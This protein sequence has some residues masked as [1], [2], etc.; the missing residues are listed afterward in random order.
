[1]NLSIT[2]NIALTHSKLLEFG[3]SDFSD[4]KNKYPPLGKCYK[5]DNEIIKGFFWLHSFPNKFNIKIHDFYFKENQIIELNTPKCLNITYYHSIS[6]EELNP[7]KKLH[8]NVV[9]CYLGGQKPF[10]ALIYKNK[11]LKSIGIDFEP[12]YYNKHIRQLVPSNYANPFD[13]FASIDACNN[14]SEMILLFRCIEKYR[15]EGISALLFYEAKVLESLS[16]LFNWYMI[17]KYNRPSFPKTDEI[18]LKTVTAYLNHHLYDKVSLDTLSKVACMSQTKLKTL[19][20]M[21]YGITIGD[22]IRRQRMAKA[23]ELMVNTQLSVN[24]IAKY[25]GYS[26]VGRFAQ[27][28]KSSMGILPKDYIKLTRKL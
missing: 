20:K 28:F 12:S 26:N 5:V 4:R 15:G 27:Y 25:V 18:G 16:I 13:A 10:Q 19:F 17:N 9:T 21:Q 14:F 11:L 8:S 1:M 22:Y 2:D 3:F 24:Q 23:E 7:H 6:G